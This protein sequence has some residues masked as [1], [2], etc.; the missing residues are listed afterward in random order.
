MSPLLKLSISWLGLVKVLEKNPTDKSAVAMSI[1]ARVVSF[2]SVI[3]YN[4]LSRDVERIQI[5]QI[6][7]NKVTN[8]Y[9]SSHFQIL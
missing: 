1:S 2:L 4:L 7:L 6:N 8:Y 5:P 9:N 3:S